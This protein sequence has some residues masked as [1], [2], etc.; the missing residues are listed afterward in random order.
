VFRFSF[1]KTLPR[2]TS[3]ID[4]TPAQSRDKGR[5]RDQ[6]RESVRVVLLVLVLLLVLDLYRSR[7]PRAILE[8]ESEKE[9]DHHPAGW[10]ALA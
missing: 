6:G 10:R 3:R 1:R 8:K 2:E 7:H 9:K 5:T 4:F